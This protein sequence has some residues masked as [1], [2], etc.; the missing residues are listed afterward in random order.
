MSGHLMR[1][2]GFGAASE[3]VR[4]RAHTRSITQF[5][6]LAQAAQAIG[7]VGNEKLCKSFKQHRIAPPS[8]KVNALKRL[9]IEDFTHVRRRSRT[10]SW[11]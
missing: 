9:W 11:P 1:T 10:V 7:R 4:E 2:K 3:P 5:E 6:S 8:N